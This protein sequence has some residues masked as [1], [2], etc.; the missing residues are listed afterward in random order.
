VF[1]RPFHSDEAAI[2]VEDEA[3]H[4]FATLTSSATKEFSLPVKAY[5][6][7]CWKI[8]GGEPWPYRLGGLMI[9][10]GCVFLMLRLISLLSTDFHSTI[11]GLAIGVFLAAH[12]G[13]SEGINSISG[14]P[15]LMGVFLLLFSL[16]SF[17]ECFQ[18]DQLRVGVFISGITAYGVGL[19][20]QPLMMIVPCLIFTCLLT[21][22]DYRK[23][24]YPIVCTALIGVTLL[25]FIQQWAARSI[26]DTQ[27]AGAIV[28][29]PNNGFY[30][31]GTKLMLSP[32]L[33]FF[34]DYSLSTAYPMYEGGAI[35][36]IGIGLIIMGFGLSYW[37]RLLGLGCVWLGIYPIFSGFFLAPDA[38][39]EY[40]GYGMIPGGLLVI[41]GLMD[42]ITLKP[43]EIALGSLMVLT[44]LVGAFQSHNRNAEWSDEMRLWESANESCL[45]CESPIARL[46]ALN[47]AK[48][49]KL[50]VEQ[51]IPIG[52][53]VREEARPYLE[54]AESW[55]LLSLNFRPVP[56]H[57][58]FNLGKINHYLGKNS[59]SL[60]WL[61]RGLQQSPE[62]QESL[63][64]YY[65]V[66]KDLKNGH[67]ALELLDAGRKAVDLSI[68]SAEERTELAQVFQQ[69]GLRK[70]ALDLLKSEVVE[71]SQLKR[72][73]IESIMNH[74]MNIPF[75]NDSMEQE[76]QIFERVLSSYVNGR[77]LTSHYRLNDYTKGRPYQL[78][79][80]VL[81]GLLANRFDQLKPFIEN[82]STFSAHSDQAVQW[83]TLSDALV[84]EGEI[85]AA[86]EVLGVGEVPRP[87]LVVGNQALD[88]GLIPGAIAQFEAATALYPD[89]YEPWLGMA[90]AALLSNKT[91]SNVGEV[92]NDFL[93]EAKSRG[94][95]AEQIQSRRSK[96]AE[97]P[98]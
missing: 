85:D 12:P 47:L 70:E 71:D 56:S 6:A 7:F 63:Y 95:S 76:Q 69:A 65:T 40:L 18:E 83:V 90:D 92:V 49:E 75:G 2:L 42:V 89:M 67:S 19:F 38:F 55:Y 34:G 16:N 3:L 54:D 66:L 88:Y 32:L 21:A 84:L 30:L 25:F 15:I 93:A 52:A 5:F 33:I 22:K 78:G 59:D 23:S 80:W 13:L 1:A 4:R 48:G 79:E 31:Q 81:A 64:D 60:I 9:H 72:R 97:Q 11:G 50:M 68:L 41:A 27:L 35:P 39:S 98:Q 77:Y 57:Y 24:F 36:W 62:K 17:I 8:G 44:S 45:I 14:V 10:L 58:L 26:L 87:E 53:D 74:Q 94:A 37:N 20:I 86:L 29:M 73:S 51:G 46:G 91:N 61:G 82:R 28:Q 96:L 43:V